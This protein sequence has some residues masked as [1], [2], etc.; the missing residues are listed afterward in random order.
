QDG[1]GDVGFSKAGLLE[2][3]T[4]A[5]QRQQQLRSLADRA[6]PGRRVEQLS[7]EELYRREPALAPGAVG[8]AWYPDDTR[9]GAGRRGGAVARAAELAGVTVRE[10]NPV[11]RLVVSG[12][13]IDAVHTDDG[14]YHPGV[15]VLAAGAWSGGL[16]EPLGLS[17]PTRPVK[18]QMLLADC[19]V[20]PVKTPLHA[21][22][23]L[24]VPR[25][26]GS[27]LLGVTVEEAGL[28]QP[29]PPPGAP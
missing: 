10:G 20:S 13:H 12:D 19:R 17:L 6:R 28:D 22:E 29:V 2:V 7:A 23:A 27:L 8:A 14:V 1:A 11:R 24:L 9:G 26:D 15:V 25:P 16:L 21:G 5:G 3:W 18:G 4:D